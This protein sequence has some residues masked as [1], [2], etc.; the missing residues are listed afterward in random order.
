M[1]VRRQTGGQAACRGGRSH[2][3]ASGSG[4]CLPDTSSRGSED[5]GGGRRDERSEAE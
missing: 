1:T 4:R 5:A 2:P 3:T